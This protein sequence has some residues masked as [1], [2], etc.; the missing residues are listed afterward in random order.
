MEYNYYMDV[1]IKIVSREQI[2]NSEHLVDELKSFCKTAS[3]DMREPAH[4]N[5]YWDNKPNT[6][7]S[8]LFHQHKYDEDTG[9][10]F[11]AYI[12]NQ[13]AGI[14]GAYTYADESN[15]LICGSRTWTMKEHRTKYLH[16]NHLFPAQFE[17]AKHNGYEKAYLTFN[18][19]NQWLFEFLQRISDGKATAFGL[20]NSD[21][22]KQLQFLPETKIINY[23][24]QHV[25]VKYL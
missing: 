10:L 25:A 14:S 15:T 22:Y 13:L 19:Y 6:L 21:T 23:T 3:N 9:R 20:S 18:S 4:V 1:E 8:Q 12:D 11:L 17:W 2:E 24:E 7:Y 16:G 5:M